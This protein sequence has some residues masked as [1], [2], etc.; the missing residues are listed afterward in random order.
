MNLSRNKIWFLPLVIVLLYPLWGNP[1]KKFLSVKVERMDFIRAMIDNENPQFRMEDFTLYQTGNGKLELKLAADAVLSGDPGSSE[2][3]LEGVRC[4]LYG[5]DDKETLI[6][7]GEA[8]YVAKQKLITIVDD[9]VVNSNSG[10]FTLETDALR[11]FTFY[12]VVKTATPV[13]LQNKDGTVRGNSLMY[14]MQTGA[15]RVTGD[16]KC[17]F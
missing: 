9:V 6:T 16:V 8:L 4:L 13:V 14:N 7:G 1:V 17:V 10:E 3:R 15:F 5:E 2:Y 11:Y 12:K